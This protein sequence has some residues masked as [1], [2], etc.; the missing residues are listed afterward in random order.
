ML[1]I[2]TTLKETA[3]KFH[4]EHCWLHHI[5]HGK[6][7]ILAVQCSDE[8]EDQNA[9]YNGYHHDTMCN[10]VL[11]F[12]PDGTI[13]YACI[14]FP[15]S[16]HDSMVCQSLIDVVMRKIGVFALCVDQGF[17]RTGELMDR[18]VGPLSKKTR[19]QLAIEL[20]ELLLARHALYISLRQS[21]EWGM[22]ALQGSFPR[23][24]SRLT[25]NKLKRSKV[26]LSIILLHNF[27]T[28]LVGLNQ[29]NTVFN[30]HYDQYIN[31]ENYD[32]IAQYF[33]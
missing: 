10:N 8:E 20:R 23:L 27:R 18:F 30:P 14:N 28:K 6:D 5:L 26:I 21:S 31:L 25:S 11:A 33:N 24:K 4:V 29:I 15:G 7:Y 19:R 32:R 17:P 2:F 16:W 9:A 3:I 12:A 1:L 22:R 13:I